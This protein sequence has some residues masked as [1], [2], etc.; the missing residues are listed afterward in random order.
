VTTRPVV[1]VTAH[2]DAPRYRG[3]LGVVVGEGRS[4]AGRTALVE[5]RC[6]GCRRYVE[7]VPRDGL[8]VVGAVNEGE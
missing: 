1:L 7:S 3:L 8:E 6:E 2:P 4:L 5:F